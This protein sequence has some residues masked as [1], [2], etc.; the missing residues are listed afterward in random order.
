M[1]AVLMQGFSNELCAKSEYEGGGRLR[2]RTQLEILPRTKKQST[3]GALR[4]IRRRTRRKFSQEEKIRV[5]LDGLREEQL[6]AM[7][8]QEG[9]RSMSPVG[10]CGGWLG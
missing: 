10:L 4:E 8:Q 3:D 6:I 2:D 5:M 1:A 9:K 7:L